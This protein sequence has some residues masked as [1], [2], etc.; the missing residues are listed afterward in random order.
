MSPGTH[1]PPTPP[2]PP[3]MAGYTHV[4]RRGRWC[5]LQLSP[6]VLDCVVV[7]RGVV[8]LHDRVRRVVFQSHLGQVDLD[9]SQPRTMVQAAKNALLDRGF[10]SGFSLQCL[11]KRETYALRAPCGAL[12]AHRTRVSTNPSVDFFMYFQGGRDAVA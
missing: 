5:G 7:F 11:A 6:H 2:I 12:R 10:Y 9:A 4:F 1:L 8:V 3:P